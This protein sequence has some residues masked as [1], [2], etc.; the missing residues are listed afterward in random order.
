[1]VLNVDSQAIAVTGEVLHTGQGRMGS[2]VFVKESREQLQG[3]CWDLYWLA[4]NIVPQQGL[5]FKKSFQRE[6]I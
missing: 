6:W 3:Q 5:T 4:N 2:L 1:M